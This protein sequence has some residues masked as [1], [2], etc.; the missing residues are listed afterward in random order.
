[1]SRR[2]L[3]AVLARQWVA[4]GLSLL[5]A[6]A[7]MA[8][9][10]L[11]LL[12]DSFIDRRLREVGEAA[13]AG[14]PVLPANFERLD[15]DAVPPELRERTATQRDGV[16]R[17]FRLPDGRYVHVL[18]GR[19]SDGSAFLLAYDVSDQLHVN[20]ALARA[21]PWLL[22][23]A[24][25]LAL[26][27]WGLAARFAADLSRR[28]GALVHGLGDAG[29]VDTLRR[30]AAGE[31]IAEFA[32]LAR[33]GADAWEARLD[34]LAR[35]RETLAFLGHELRTPLQSA[36][37]SLASLHDDRGDQRAWQRLQR[38]HDR[39]ARASHAILW[40]HRDAA[41][42]VDAHCDAAALLQAL[43]DEFAPLAG[44]RGQSIELSVPPGTSWPCPPELAETI[45]ANL[46]LNAVQHGS[47]GL[48]TVG[49]DF[50]G[51]VVD[52]PTPGGGDRAGFGVGLPLVERLLARVGGSLV[53][54][55]MPA[56]HRIRIRF[57]G[58]QNR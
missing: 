9:L 18:A 10:L 37:T 22:A 1:M 7:A 43:A 53:R 42:P 51:A 54:E 31:D 47:P 46:L 6:F 21:W 35:E 11:F 44:R 30:H 3:R 41:P 28:A 12:E 2:S 38:A 32:D 29:D 19:G 36:R 14:A 5:A 34:T 15:R 50:D 4:F 55:Q 13:A 48:I 17:E 16:V 25:L 58:G 56:R 23:M 39:L 45:V 52:N 20:A 57:P 26:L 49:A 27:A 33:L 24:S 8:L 40:L